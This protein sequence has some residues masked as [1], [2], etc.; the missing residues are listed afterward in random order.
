MR[1]IG[2]T[3]SPYVRRIRILLEGQNHQLELIDVF[4]AEGQRY[5]EQFTKTRRIPVLVD[6]EKV[7]WDSY[8]IAKHI[9]GSKFDHSFDQHLFLINEASD[10]GIHLLQFNRFGMDEKWENKLS[11]N[12]LKRVTDILEFF[13]HYY[14]TK[15]YEQTWDLE[16]QWLYCLLDWLKFRGIYNWEDKCEALKQFYAYH[17]EDDIILA[18]DPRKA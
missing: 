11:Q 1:L 17:Q 5:L 10:S 14:Q 4:S 8:L 2:S 3:S 9:L 6:G 13:N 7:I 16:D 18:T 15:N 12:H